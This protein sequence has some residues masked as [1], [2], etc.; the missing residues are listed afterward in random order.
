MKQY[1]EFILSLVFY[2][3]SA[4]GASLTIK[5]AIGVSA[6]TAMNVAIS[7]GTAIKVGTVTTIMN[8]VFLFAYMCSSRFRYPVKY[9]LQAVFVLLFGVLINFFVYGVFRDIELNQYWVRVLVLAAGTIIGG[10][11]VGKVIAYNVITFPIENFCMDLE[12][13]TGKKFIYY[14]YGVDVF[15]VL[16]SIGISLSMALPL[17][18]REGTILNMLL[19]TAAMN[20][21]RHLGG[22]KKVNPAES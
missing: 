18:I 19:L 11:A 12:A 16:V 9:L 7:Q 4:F 14:R 20:L 3:I 8:L 5:A 17:F 21:T 22:S 10:L 2:A 1:K 13:L 6:F 15:S